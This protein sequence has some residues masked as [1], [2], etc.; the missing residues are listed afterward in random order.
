MKNARGLIAD[1]W[2]NTALTFP[3]PCPSPTDLLL[4]AP[5]ES[6][7][8]SSSSSSCLFLFHFYFCEYLKKKKRRTDSS[9]KVCSLWSVRHLPLT[10]L[11]SFNFLSNGK[12]RKREKRG[13][14]QKRT[15][16]WLSSPTDENKR[17]PSRRV[18]ILTTVPTTWQFPITHTTSS[19]Q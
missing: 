16:E 17:L 8:L 12:E 11:K 4:A 2:F 15:T 10:I 19:A 1:G 6:W 13:K 9:P 14:K 3:F 7:C 5:V 18:L